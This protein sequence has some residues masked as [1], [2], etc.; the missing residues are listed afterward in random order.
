MMFY[1]FMHL[2]LICTHYF[3]IKFVLFTKMWPLLHTYKICHFSRYFVLFWNLCAFFKHFY[4]KFRPQFPLK[5]SHFQICK[6]CISGLQIC[7]NDF[8]YFQINSFQKFCPIKHD[9]FR[10][11]TERGIP[12]S[13][14]YVRN[15]CIIGLEIPKRRNNCI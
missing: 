11:A 6:A 13:I 10:E 4:Y 9:M 14:T 7:K 8:I 2:H 15:G 12:G 3:I 1:T 5:Q